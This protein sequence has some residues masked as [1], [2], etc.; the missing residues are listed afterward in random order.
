MTTSYEPT[1]RCQIIDLLEE[2][3]PASVL[4]ECKIPIYVCEWLVEYNKMLVLNYLHGHC[5]DSLITLIPL[6]RSYIRY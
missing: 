3:V 2:G 4:D 6:Y 5:N 1:K